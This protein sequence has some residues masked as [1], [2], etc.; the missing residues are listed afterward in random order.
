[1]KKKKIVKIDFNDKIYG[2]RIYENEVVRL[3]EDEFEFERV[4]IM[5]YRRLLPNLVRAIWLLIKYKFFFKGVL[6]LTNSTSLFANRRSRTLIVV[7]HLEKK[8][9]AKKTANVR[10]W[11]QNYCDRYFTNHIDKFNQVVA[12][13]RFWYEELKRMKIDNLEL[14]YNSFNPGDY[15]CSEEQKKDFRKKYG[16][17]GKPLVYLGSC[18]EGK[19]VRQSYES[20]KNL[21]IHMVTSGERHV[22]LPIPNLHLSYEEY[23]LLIASSDIVIAMSQFDEGWNRGVHEASLSGTR[24]IGTAR[25]G[26]KE[27]MELADQTVIESFDDLQDTVMKNIGMPY[28]PT[29]G[30]LHLDLNYFKKEWRRVLK[31]I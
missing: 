1:M 11:F 16:L 15:Q 12:V 10:L 6:F 3:L 18:R 29:E 25:A 4:Y 30:L 27:L 21:D 13:S 14:I 19:G 31:D 8:N 26:M 5:K 20:L 24:V 7:H 23:K 28:S 9:P 17:A 22:D 2:G